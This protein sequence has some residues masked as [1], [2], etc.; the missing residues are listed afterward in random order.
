MM[1]SQEFC[2]RGIHF[3]NVSKYTCTGYGD[4]E[5]SQYNPW[6]LETAMPQIRKGNRD[7]SEVIFLISHQKC[8]LSPLICFYGENKIIPLFP[9]SSGALYIHGNWKYEVL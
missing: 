3:R 8:M 9:F 7:N 4:L 2:Q 5:L 6:K 1:V